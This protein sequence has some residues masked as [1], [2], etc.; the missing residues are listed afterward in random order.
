MSARPIRTVRVLSSRQ[1]RSKK[2]TLLAVQ[3]CRCGSCGQVRS[4][5]DL[6]LKHKVHRTAGGSSRLDNLY[7][8]CR[9]CNAKGHAPKEE[10]NDPQQ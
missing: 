5:S 3:G 4:G 8:I 6:I 1:R 7:L 10:G 9:V 2:R